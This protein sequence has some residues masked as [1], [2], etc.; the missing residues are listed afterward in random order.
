MIS[1]VR[2]CYHAKKFIINTKFSL[3]LVLAIFKVYNKNENDASN[4]NSGTS[5]LILTTL[6]VL[7]ESKKLFIYTDAKILVSPSGPCKHT[8]KNI[9]VLHLWTP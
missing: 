4:S 3:S 2:L 1:I 6:A 5:Y 7:H 8:E 9:G